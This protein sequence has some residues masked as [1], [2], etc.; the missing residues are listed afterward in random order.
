MTEEASSRSW[1]AYLPA[2]LSLSVTRYLCVTSTTPSPPLTGLS[3]L[4]F[5]SRIH[6]ATSF[7]LYF[8]LQLLT[9]QTMA[10]WKGKWTPNRIAQERQVDEGKLADYKHLPQQDVIA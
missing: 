2:P 7:Q 8:P 6:P 10:S 4:S 1:S 5:P 3:W 9:E